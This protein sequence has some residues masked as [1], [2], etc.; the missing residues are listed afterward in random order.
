MYVLSQ[1]LCS[2]HSLSCKDVAHDVGIQLWYE[3]CESGI[4]DIRLVV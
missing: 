3:N 4:G 2:L 1:R